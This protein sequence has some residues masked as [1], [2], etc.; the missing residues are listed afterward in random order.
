MWRTN[1]LPPHLNS[2]SSHVCLPNK[3]GPISSSVRSRTTY[4]LC[5]S[6][7]EEDH[8]Y[9]PVPVCTSF[10]VRLYPDWSRLMKVLWVP[11]WRGKLQTNL[12]FD[13]SKRYLFRRIFRL[14]APLLE[15]SSWLV[16][17]LSLNWYFNVKGLLPPMLTFPLADLSPDGLLCMDTSSNLSNLSWFSF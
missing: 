15:P 16:P 4:C 6:F 17:L 12:V 2:G 8:I 11:C 3:I 13:F 14:A 7:V 9:S 10:L 1:T 5:S